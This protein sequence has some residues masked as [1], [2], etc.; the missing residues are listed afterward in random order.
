MVQGDSLKG[1][2]QYKINENNN[3]KI[4]ILSDPEFK[5]ELL[6][7]VETFVLNAFTFLLL[8]IQNNVYPETQIFVAVS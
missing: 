3:D 5:H 1:K 6:L 7:S 8:F 2:M 4:L